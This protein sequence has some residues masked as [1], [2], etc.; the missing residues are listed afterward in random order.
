MVGHPQIQVDGV[1]SQDRRQP[2]ARVTLDGRALLLRRVDDRAVSSPPADVARPF[3]KVAVH[4]LHHV[5][6]EVGVAVATEIQHHLPPRRF[7]PG[8]VRGYFALELGRKGIHL[9]GDHAHF[10]GDHA[11]SEAGIARARGFEAGVHR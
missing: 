6:R 1:G 7:D 3:I 8:A 9:L 5:T 11:K 10:P 4:D 2:L